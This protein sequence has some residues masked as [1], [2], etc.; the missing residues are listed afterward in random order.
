MLFYWGARLF[1]KARK[2]SQTIFLNSIRSQKGQSL[3]EVLIAG[4]VGLA[5]VAALSHLTIQQQKIA[6]YLEDRLAM[7]ELRKEID[8]ILKS[9]A[10][11]TLSLNGVL[12]S[13][14]P[15]NMVI[16]DATATV[17]YD[18]GDATK[19]RFQELQISSIQLVDKT[20]GGPNASGQV[21]V[22]IGIQRLRPGMGAANSRLNYTLQVT[23]DNSTLVD[24][25]GGMSS[26]AV[27]FISSVVSCSETNA[28]PFS[29]NLGSSFQL[30]GIGFYGNDTDNAWAGCVIERLGQEWVLWAHCNS[31]TAVNCKANCI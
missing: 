5:V 4:G 14:T 18:P 26:G 30:C 31:V 13:A 21:E 15:Q 29:L 16:S 23:S 22:Q 7:A 19:N 8:E 27:P 3:T 25:C 17:V 12:I 9:S 28:G 24:Q 6:N 10:A 11:C 20:V 2:S 1:K